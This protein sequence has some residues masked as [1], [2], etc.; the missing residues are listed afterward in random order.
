MREKML[1]L[2]VSFSLWRILLITFEAVKEVPI[3]SS[4]FFD[5]LM[6]FVK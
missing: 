4:S 3:G 5:E 2:N 6:Y 1:S